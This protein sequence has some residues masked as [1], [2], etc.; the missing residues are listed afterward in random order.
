MER[1]PYQRHR[2]RWLTVTVD[3]RV[4]ASWIPW[5]HYELQR[6]TAHRLDQII[7]TCQWITTASGGSRKKIFGGLAGWPGPS[8]FG[9]QQRLSEITIEP[10]KNL[11]AWA[12]FGGSVPPG[13]KV[14]P[15]LTT[16]FDE[17]NKQRSILT[18]GA[19]SMAAMGRKPPRPTSW[20]GDAPKSPPQEFCY[21]NFLKR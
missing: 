2:P 12:R 18:T 10:I 5:G 8:S 3:R 19:Y 16:A 7:S 21:V 1:A 11:G 20:R 15:S 13:P 17:Q 6:T 14:E 4:T 9:R